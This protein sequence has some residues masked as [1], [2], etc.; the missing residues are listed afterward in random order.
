MPRL[1]ARLGLVLC[2]WLAA[3]AG[4]QAGEPVRLYVFGN[5]LIHHPSEVPDTNMPVWLGRLARAGGQ[6]LAL[7][8]QSGW[9]REFA[10]DLPPRPTWR[11]AG[12]RGVWLPARQDFAEAGFNRFLIA[13][14]NFIQYQAPDRAY[15]D[16]SGGRTTPLRATLDLIDW[17]RGQ[18]P[19][20]RIL[21]YQGWADMGDMFDTVP[22]DGA[23]LAAYHALNAGKYDAWFQDWMADLRAARPEA[24]LA[25]VPVARVMAR[26]FTDSPLAE[27]APGALYTDN[28]PHGTPTLYLLAA[29]ITYPV[30]FDAP[31]PAEFRPPEGIDPILR[32]NYAGVAQV[33]WQEVAGDR[34]RASTGPGLADPALAMGLNGISDWTTQQPFVD[35]FRTARPWIG[36]SAEKWGAWSNDDLAAG[37]YLGGAGWPS[38]LPEGAT[39]L[40]ALVLTDQ[41]EASA[42]VLA[43]RYRVT[44][45]GSG[46]LELGGRAQD[47]S[48]GDHE[49]WFSYTPGEGAVAVAITRTD[50]DGTGDN[51][52]NIRVVREDNIA[53]FEA[54]A[55]FNPDWLAVIADMRALRFMDW[56]QTNNSPVREWADRPRLSDATWSGQ[57][58]PPE[59]MIELANTVGADPW[60]TMPHRADDTYIRRFAE[61]VR[62]RLDPNLVAHVEYSNELWNFTFEQAGWARDQARARWGARAE[63]D[64]WMQ[65][66]GLRAAQVMD[67]WTEVFGAEAPARLRRIV[68]VHTGWPGLEEAQLMAPLARAEGLPAPADSFDAYAVA[69][70]FGHDLGADDMADQLRTWQAMPGDAGIAEAAQALRQGALAELLDDLLPY[71]A[72]VAAE[73]GLALIMY[74]GGTHVVAQGALVNDPALTDFFIRLNYSNEMAVLYDELLLG[75]RAAGGTLFNAFVDVAAPTK[76]GS[77]GALRHLADNNP[78][79]QVLVEYDRAGAGW[80]ARA[81]DTF[82]NGLILWGTDADDVQEGS[83]KPDILI[84]GPGDD[85]LVGNG[86]ADH[87]NGGAGFDIAVLPGAPGDWQFRRAGAHIEATGPDGTNTLFA[88]EMAQFTAAPG[89]VLMLDDLP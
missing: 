20:A 61:M 74:E 5:S 39:R 72:R 32:A 31:L 24:D 4:A 1:L 86:G 42:P 68:A 83:P 58:V 22:A 41:P 45:Q 2:L 56:M 14:E 17:L 8:G 67:I 66:A 84:A 26:L 33:I 71:H 49:A 37:G 10:R 50:P 69:G 70:Y 54:G 6:S 12:L 89:T 60:F 82:L 18:A 30:L 11:V 21:L 7:D 9:L 27:I 52:R 23:D 3:T 53:L 38:A 40:E 88:V 51:I 62:D 44:W 73:N 35:V 76:Y 80:E 79:W 57:G 87:L 77:W 81:P 65:F 59:V 78:R 64:G 36:H 85:V 46:D 25:L 34:A 19:D 43:G 15:A 13:P 63:G 47:V 75:W 55:L 29:M 28:A 48:M 16:R